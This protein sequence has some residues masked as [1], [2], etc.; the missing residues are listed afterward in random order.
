MTN[1]VFIKGTDGPG[2]GM[3][4]IAGTGAGRRWSA[5]IERARGVI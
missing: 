5:G 4:Q 1:F 3:I 2:D